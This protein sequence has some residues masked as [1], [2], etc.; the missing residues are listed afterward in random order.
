MIRAW[1][2]R[3]IRGA[4]R[5]PANA[6]GAL[7]HSKIALRRGDE[8]ARA[9]GA[10]SIEGRQGQEAKSINWAKSSLPS[11]RATEEASPVI[12]NECTKPDSAT[13]PPWPPAF[14]ICVGMCIWPGGWSCARACRVAAPARVARRAER[15]LWPAQR[16]IL[17]IYRPGVVFLSGKRR[18][19][20]RRDTTRPARCARDHDVHALRA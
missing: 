5:A 1:P 18:R 9:R 12:Q 4:F 10:R 20:T 2:P 8:C 7:R 19:A 3:A 17:G 11:P 16:E 14:I 13:P 15:A 6:R